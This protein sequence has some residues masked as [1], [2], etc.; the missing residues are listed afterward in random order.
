MRVWRQ[1]TDLVTRHGSAALISV[2]DV[3]GSAPREAGARMAVRP[4][5]AFHGTIGGGQLEFRML[6]IAREMLQAGRGPARIVDQ[7]LGPDLGQ[8]CGGRV[9]ILIETFDGRDLDD[10]APLVEAEAGGGPFEVECRM[11]EGRVRRE[12]ASAVGDDR[13]TG[14][15]ETHG[16][17]RTPV[18]LFGAGHVGRALVLSLAPLPFAVRWLDDR[19]DAFPSHVPANARAVRLRDP[20]AEI[21]GADPAS[22]ILVMTHDH[23]LDMAITAAALKRAFPYVGLIGSATK[24]A[25]FEKRFRELHLP[26][27]RI[28][29]LV[30]PIG[31]AGIADKDPAVIAA[32]VT[33]QLLQVREGGNP[34]R[35]LSPPAPSNDT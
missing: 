27:E 10:L 13:W 31:L 11:E 22:L 15:H 8:C 4:D 21:A 26:E 1:L 24:R 16:V 35:N 28:R 29:A 19:E 14:W 5:G 12:L 7:A 20:E 9:A 2:H 23:P 3:K 34:E 6:D 25:R 17:A 33:A 30:C 32:S 18:L